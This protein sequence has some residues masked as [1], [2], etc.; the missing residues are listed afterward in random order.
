MHLF[1]FSFYKI[2]PIHGKNLG[3]SLWF[4]VKQLLAERHVRSYLCLV[5]LSHGFSFNLLTK[6]WTFRLGCVRNAEH[7]RA[8]L[9]F[10]GLESAIVM[11]S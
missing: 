8:S 2:Y 10:F 6:F 1:S 7:V 4:E 11:Q 9:R 3:C 5:G